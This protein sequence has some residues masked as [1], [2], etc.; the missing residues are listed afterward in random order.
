[1]DDDPEDGAGEGGIKAGRAGCGFLQFMVW[2]VGLA[3]EDEQV[4]RSR[5]RQD[6]LPVSSGPDR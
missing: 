5:W 4:T 6:G 2:R 1:M 3:E